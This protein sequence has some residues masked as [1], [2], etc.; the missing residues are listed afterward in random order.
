M[1][2]GDPI[3]ITYNAVA[4]NLVK[5]NQDSYG[6]EYYLDEGTTRFHLSI[7]HT[8]PPKG[9]PG[10]SHLIRLD[11]ETYD[12]DDILLRTSSAW[13]VAKTFDGKQN[14]TTSDYVCQALVDLLTDGNVDKLLARES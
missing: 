1:A 10:E 7:K 14:T 9:A 3:A 11:V 12:A 2:F 4:K 8:I 13:L 6:A 5:I